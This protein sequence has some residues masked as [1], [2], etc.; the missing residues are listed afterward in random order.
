M[1]SSKYWY[2][3][4]TCS[5][6]K[7]RL[8]KIQ[9]EMMVD[10]VFVPAKQLCPVWLSSFNK[11]AELLELPKKKRAQQCVETGYWR[12]N[13]RY[14]SLQAQ[15]YCSFLDQGRRMIINTEYVKSSEGIL[16]F[17]EIVSIAIEEEGKQS[18]QYVWTTG[19]GL[20]VVQHEG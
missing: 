4:M 6:C 7:K 2:E 13:M 17:M 19:R 1:E 20:D 11:W 9:H 5:Y 3:I 10:P 14:V 18:K 16:K 12:C 8:W 15:N